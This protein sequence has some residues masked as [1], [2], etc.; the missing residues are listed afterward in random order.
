MAENQAPQQL[1]LADKLDQLF[2]AVH[3]AGRGEYTYE[4][5]V[6]GIRQRGGPTISVTQLWELRNGKKTNPRKNHLEALATFFRMPSS[7]FFNDDEAT[8][9]IHTELKLLAAIRDSQIRR[10]IARA[11]DLSPEACS[12]VTEMIERLRHLQGLTNGEA[13]TTH[14]D[15]PKTGEG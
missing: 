5:V 15:P 12:A 14:N 2:R 3:P 9:Q 8:I 11:S 13:R 7:Y 1:T 4:E 10:I 6:E